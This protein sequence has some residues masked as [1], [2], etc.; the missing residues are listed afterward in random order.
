MTIWE[1]INE[2]IAV[3]I[4]LKKI[5]KKLKFQFIASYFL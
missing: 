2:S 3:A 1:S 5:Y 4:N